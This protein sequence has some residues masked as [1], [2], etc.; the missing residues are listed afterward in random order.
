MNPHYSASMRTDWTSL[1]IFLLVVLMSPATTVGQIVDFEDYGLP[2]GEVI[3][4]G[5]GETWT[6]GGIAFT[7]GPIPD[8]NESH[9]GNAVEFWG[10]NGTH[11]G[12]WHHDMVL[13]REGGGAFTLESFDFSGFPTGFEVPFTVTAQPGNVVASFS[14]DG[15]VDGLGGV[16]DFETFFLPA[17]FANI[18]SATWDH[19]GGGTLIGLVAID[20]ISVPGQP[21]LADIDSSGDVG[22]GDL[23]DVLA[24][25]GPCVGCPQ[26][27]DGD[28]VV[29]FTDLLIVLSSWGPCP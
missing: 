17:G 3:D 22:F 6:S 16:E 4:F 25:W 7:P 10:Y 18:T 12:V 15:L 20:N 2:P 28:D 14:P 13:T 29:G 27:L 11:V 19:T 21:C 9:V 8:D 5:S 1:A 24:N 23:L 26:D